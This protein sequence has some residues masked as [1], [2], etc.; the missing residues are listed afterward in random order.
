[1]EGKT[2]I[3]L[4]NCWE[5]KKEVYLSCCVIQWSSLF[6]IAWFY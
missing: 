2:E 6:L 1:M 4:Y 3:Y 5:Y